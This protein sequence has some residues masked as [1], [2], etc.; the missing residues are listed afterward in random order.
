MTDETARPERGWTARIVEIFI[1]SKLSILFLLASLAAGAVALLATPRE[2]E[3]QIVVPFADVIVEM[4]GATAAEV[5]NLVATPLESKLW[6]IDGVEYVYSQARPGQAV[7]TVRC[8]AR[9]TATTSPRTAGR[10][11]SAPASAPCR[12]CCA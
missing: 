5:E 1:T 10:A 9:P 3:P 11:T 4:P 2:E 12:A 8:G 7:V 6:E